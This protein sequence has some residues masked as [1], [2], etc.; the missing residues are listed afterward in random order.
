MEVQQC[1]NRLSRCRI[2][3]P[4]A[5]TD[6]NSTKCEEEERCR[7]EILEA[8]VVQARR[9]GAESYIQ[10]QCSDGYEGNL[11]G[12]CIQTGDTKYGQRSAFVCVECTGHPE[13]AFTLSALGTA[14]VLGL[15]TL[16]SLGNNQLGF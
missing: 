11:C 7:Y 15:S 1:Y 14:V 5:A 16:L 6:S 4:D 3:K 9:V 2:N 8:A 13:L 10:H 12:R